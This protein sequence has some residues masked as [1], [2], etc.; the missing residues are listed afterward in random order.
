MAGKSGLSLRS[1]WISISRSWMKIKALATFKIGNGNRVGFWID[2]WID[3]LPLNLRFPSIFRITAEHWDQFS[4]SWIECFCRLLKDDEIIEFQRLLGL[5]KDFGVCDRPD[6]R[7]WTLEDNGA[8][9]VKSLVN[10]LS[11]SSLLDKQVERALW[12]SKSP[13]RVNITVWIM[14]FGLLNCGSVMQKK[15]PAHMLSPLACPL[16]L[17]AFEDLQHLIVFMLVN[18]GN[19]YLEFLT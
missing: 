13:R 1:P 16:C 7:V 6:R 5:L 8:F 18:V 12:K 19:S 2:P 9:S 4:S 11:F 3:K 10:H 15:L 17:L 14:I